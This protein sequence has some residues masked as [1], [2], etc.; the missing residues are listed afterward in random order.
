M[1]QKI[2]GKLRDGN[3]HDREEKRHETRVKEIGKADDLPESRY[4]NNVAF[5]GKGYRWGQI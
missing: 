2:D 3:T 5:D 1:C 4:S